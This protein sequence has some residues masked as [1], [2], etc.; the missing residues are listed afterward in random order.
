MFDDLDD[1]ATL[2]DHDVTRTVDLVDEIAVDEY[3]R[4]D[5]AEMCIR[6]RPPAMRKRTGRSSSTGSK[7]PGCDQTSA[8]STS[9]K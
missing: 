9:G 3:R 6:D 5:P 1:P 7:S 8:L 2:V 4:K